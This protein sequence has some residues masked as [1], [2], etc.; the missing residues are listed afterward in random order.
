MA[1]I[2][3]PEPPQA[4]PLERVVVAL[5]QPVVV[6]VVAPSGEDEIVVVGELARAP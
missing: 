6:Q 2:V 4:G 3:E 5:A 1:Q